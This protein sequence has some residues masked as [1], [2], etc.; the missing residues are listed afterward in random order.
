M[1][2]I[3]GKYRSRRLQTLPGL[4]LRPTADRL[5]ETLFNV[6]TAGNP[7][8][9]EGTVW[10]DLYAGTGAVGIEAL[11]RG[12]SMLHFVE[13]SEGAVRLIG[14][15]LAS[16]AIAAGFQILKQDSIRALRALSSNDT[17]ADFIFLDPP[18]E[19]KE[20]YQ[21]ALETLSQSGLLKHESIVV[22]EHQKKFDPGGAIG[23]LRRYRKLV[24]GDAALSFYRL[25]PA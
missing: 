17:V 25:D 20:A 22:A 6:L 11:S 8:A 10:V 1:R 19:M 2:V 18:Y 12:A 23:S 13:L 15:N 21:Q 3:G 5:R 7:A 16:L 14:K 4:E 9:L 24:Q